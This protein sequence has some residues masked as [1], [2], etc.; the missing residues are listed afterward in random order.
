[1]ATAAAVAKVGKSVHRIFVGNL[2]WTVGHQEL[3]GYFRE[4]G[5]VVSANVIFD[6]RTGCSK[7]YGFVSFNS[8]AALEKIENEQKHVL[9]GNYL[10]IQ[11]S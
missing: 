10:N 7:G 9:E 5:R 11:K 1:M 2:P 6:K 4:F 3:R 8:L